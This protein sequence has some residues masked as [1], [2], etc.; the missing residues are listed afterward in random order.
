MNESGGAIVEGADRFRYDA[1]CGR[2]VGLED[3]GPLHDAIV[4]ALSR[5]SA[6]GS[7]AE[8]R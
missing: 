4:L 3:T 1:G 6:G 7:P 5:S 8:G 2:M